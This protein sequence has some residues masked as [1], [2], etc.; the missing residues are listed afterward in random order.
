MGSPDSASSS[1]M[2][3]LVAG[4]NS[5]GEPVVEKIAVEVLEPASSVPA[6]AGASSGSATP[7]QE[8]RLQK[9]PAFVRG[10]AAGDRIRHPSKR[11]AGYDLLQRSGNL[12]IRVLR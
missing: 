10:L 9:S 7:A 4:F 3:S 2:L 8:Y 11:Q 6:A 1:D 12:A 5:E